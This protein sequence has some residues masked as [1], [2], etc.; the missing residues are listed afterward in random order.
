M[1]ESIAKK[2]SLTTMEPICELEGPVETGT[3]LERVES[4][5]SRSRVPFTPK[6][7]WDLFSHQLG[8][9]S[10]TS[11]RQANKLDHPL[12]EGIMEEKRNG[13]KDSPI[14]TRSKAVSKDHVAQ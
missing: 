11:N 5:E 8:R 10:C 13:A 6:V 3:A 9:G 12:E 1:L 14:Q 2:R 7:G 4:R